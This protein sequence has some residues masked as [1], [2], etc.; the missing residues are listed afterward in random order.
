VDGSDGELLR[1][2][3][4]AAG[5]SITDL[6]ATPA[7]GIG[8]TNRNSVG[9]YSYPTAIELARTGTLEMVI[10]SYGDQV[11][12]VN[13]STRHAVRRINVGSYPVAVAITP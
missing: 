9:L 12:L 10:D 2:L 3:A 13:T 4:E 11:T 8:S 1:G 6:S 7:S 5:L